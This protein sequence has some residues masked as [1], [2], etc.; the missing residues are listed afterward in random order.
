[1]T[2]PLF[3]TRFCPSPTGLMHLGN[4][5]TGLFNV[6]LTK[7][8]AANGKPSDFLLRIEDSDP[9]RSKHLFTES[10][11]GDLEWM[12]L[13]WQ[14]GPERDKGN[15][16]YFQ[17]KRHDLY[18]KYYQQLIDQ[19]QAYWCYCTEAELTIVRRN[20]INAHQPPRYAGT[21]RHL[22]EEQRAEK[23]ANGL[24]P[25]LRFRIP[26][27]ETVAFED[28]IQGNKVFSTSDIGDF[29]IKKADGS[30]SFMFCNA[31]DDALMGVTH[32]MRGEDHLTNSP[33]QLLILK[34]LGLPISTYGHMPLI[35]G[36]DGKPLSKRNGSQSVESLRTAGY[37]PI[38][39]ANYLARLGHHYTQENLLSLN[40]LGEHFDTK[41][42]SRSPARFDEQQLTHWQ[43]EVVMQLDMAAFW[44][45]IA[46]EVK[47]LIDA[48]QAEAFCECVKDNVVYPKDALMWAQQLL[49]DQFEFDEAAKAQIDSL[50]ETRLHAIQKAI[51]AHGEDYQAIVADIK[52]NTDL[53][54]KALFMGL[55]SLFSGRTFGPELA[56]IVSLM[57]KELLLYRIEWVLHEMKGFNR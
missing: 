48:K 43:K 11:C 2:D 18:A 7:S 25:A 56:K 47:H 23:E 6:L 46:P 16:P 3:K 27:D 24:K 38:A 29:I 8:L 51:Q 10:I 13:T 9:V 33:R 50:G 52:A 21:C 19:K 15:G 34:A 42:I 41:H 54:G 28:F 20:Q 26:D 45:W 36:F 44:D 14:E 31:V 57:G 12:G 5:R 1:M 39:L 49:T 55:R 40:E 35:L 4:L 30:S 17:S 53:K 22:T 37:F 32:V